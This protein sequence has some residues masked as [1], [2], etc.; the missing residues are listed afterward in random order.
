MQLCVLVWPVLAWFTL[1]RYVTC[2]GCHILVTFQVQSGSAFLSGGWSFVSFVQVEAYNFSWCLGILF[3][4]KAEEEEGEFQ[5]WLLTPALIPAADHWALTRHSSL[6]PGFLASPDI[7]V[8][9]FSVFN[10]SQTWFPI[11]SMEETLMHEFQRRRQQ[12]EP[13]VWLHQQV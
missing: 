10:I 2:P 12:S 5:L 4:L 6:S 11:A 3:S 9:Q 8:I 7:I 13:A 1:L